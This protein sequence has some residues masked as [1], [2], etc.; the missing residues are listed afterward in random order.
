MILNKN[1]KK[2]ILIYFTVAVLLHI[3]KVIICKFNINDFISI[4]KTKS[5]IFNGWTISHLILNA[6]VG[7]IFPNEIYISIIL[8]II[9][10]IYEYIY[11]LNFPILINLYKHICKNS[12]EKIILYNPY[13]FII[14][15]IGILIGKYL[16]FIS[17]R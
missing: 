3:Y 12:P 8:G 2:V 9:W 6:I 5:L 15:I 13:D 10:E 11:S 4:N 7:Y 14:N 17:S 1:K 16:S